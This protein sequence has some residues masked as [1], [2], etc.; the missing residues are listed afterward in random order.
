MP[1]SKTVRNSSE[2]FVEVQRKFLKN[3]KILELKEKLKTSLNG[4]INIDR[5]RLLHNQLELENETTLAEI[6]DPNI[7]FLVTSKPYLSAPLK[8]RFSTWSSH[9]SSI[10]QNKP[11]F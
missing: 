10:M 8:A 6:G 7:I 4:Q 9:P 11:I 5:L 3:V 2:V 1:N